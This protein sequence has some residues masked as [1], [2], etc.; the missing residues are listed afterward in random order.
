MPQQSS[1]PSAQ[2]ETVNRITRLT[3]K[4]PTPARATLEVE[5]IVSNLR[6]QRD[7]EQFQAWL[8]EMRDR[9]A[10]AAEQA[11]EAV[12]EVEDGQ[13]AERRKA[14]NAVACLRAIS[15]TFGVALLVPAA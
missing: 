14:E 3:Q 4:E 8:E 6:Q 12:S 11:A 9:F 13:K 2:R 5:T 10:E 7:P 1:H 15:V